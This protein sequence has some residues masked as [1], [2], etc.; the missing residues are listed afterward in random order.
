MRQ[1]RDHLSAS[2]TAS[3][4]HA[5]CGDVF[6]TPAAVLSRRRT[7]GT[8]ARRSQRPP[9]EQRACPP[10]HRVPGGGDNRDDVR[11]QQR[12]AGVTGPIADCGVVAADAGQGSAHGFLPGRRLVAGAVMMMGDRGH[13][14]GQGSGRIHPDTVRAD[15]VGGVDKVGR[16]RR[17]VRRQRGVGRACDTTARTAATPTRRCGGCPRTGTRPSPAP[18]AQPPPPTDLETP[19]CR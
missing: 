11:G 2:G 5:G 10:G 17:R 9:E 13:P 19:R 1:A 7:R 12:G 16:D 6:L 4:T 14:L 15:G 18:S 3:W 8:G